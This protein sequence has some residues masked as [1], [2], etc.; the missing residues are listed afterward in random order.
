MPGL[1]DTLAVVDGDLDSIPTCAPLA[2]WTL[3]G[4]NSAFEMNDT[5]LNPIAGIR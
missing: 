4:V 3:R 5:S 2:V 1:Q